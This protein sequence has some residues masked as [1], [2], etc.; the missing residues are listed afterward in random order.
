MMPK[1]GSCM[2]W[3]REILCMVCHLQK[4]ENCWGMKEHEVCSF[5]D[6]QRVLMIVVLD[7]WQSIVYHHQKGVK[8]WEVV[9]H[10]K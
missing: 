2:M 5:D 6:W 4:G 10:I 9:G 8:C 3:V 1:G 7:V